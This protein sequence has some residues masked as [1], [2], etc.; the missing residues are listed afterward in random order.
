MKK[1]ALVIALVLLAMVVAG[2][3]VAA[4]D[5]AALYKAKCQACHGPDG[6][7]GTE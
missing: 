6:S 2:P 4:E 3:I 7:P 5:G 1:T